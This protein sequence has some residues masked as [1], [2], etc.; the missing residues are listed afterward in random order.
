MSAIEYDIDNEPQRS[1]DEDTFRVGD[2]DHM[3]PL[4]RISDPCLLRERHAAEPDGA[5]RAATGAWRRSTSGSPAA[6]SRRRQT[7]SPT[8]R[9]PI[10]SSS[11][12]APARRPCLQN[13]LRWQASAIR[14]TKVVVVGYYNDIA[15]L[16]RTHP[17]RHFRIY[18]SAGRHARHHGGDG[19]PSSSIRTPNR[20]AAASPSSAP[21]AA[22]APRRI[23]HNC[24]FGISSLFSTETILADLDLPYG[25]ANIDFDQDPAQGI[26]EAVFAPERLDEVFLDRLLTKCSDASVAA[27]RTLD[28]R[29]RL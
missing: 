29:P 16:S 11:K 8:L 4:P 17:Q 14:A 26:A 15:A 13:S 21:R 5:L 27:G 22:W 3:R 28:A 23:A 2:L 20:S 1:L 19:R 24:A 10:S 18:G 7:C 9:R 25:T 12:H 6:A